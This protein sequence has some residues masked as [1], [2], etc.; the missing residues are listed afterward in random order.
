M[1]QYRG[2]RV[3]IKNQ[4]G[5]LYTAE[6]TVLV[7]DGSGVWRPLA[8]RL[9]LRNHSPTGFEWGYGGSGPAQT[10]LAILA[11]LIGD[12]KALGYYQ[13]FKWEVLSRQ[14][15]DEWVLNEPEVRDRIERIRARRWLEHQKRVEE[16]LPADCRG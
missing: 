5:Y 3:R 12:E 16:S 6:T 4:W 11:D 7:G 8:L 13:D 9:D 2:K 15:A 14:G 1:K 10:A